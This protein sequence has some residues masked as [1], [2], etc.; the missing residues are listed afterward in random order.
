[1]TLPLPTAQVEQ[2]REAARSGNWVA[3]LEL[4]GQAVDASPTCPHTQLAKGRILRA[5]GGDNAASLLAFRKASDYA[6]ETALR[7][8]ALREYA[9]GLAT[10]G[11]NK[12]A[13]CALEEAITLVQ[14]DTGVADTLL[15]ELYFRASRNHQSSGNLERA[16]ACHKLSFP[17]YRDR[18]GDLAS[19]YAREIGLLEQLGDV[20]ALLRSYARLVELNPDRVLFSHPPQRQTP[21]NATRLRNL[22]LGINAH[23]NKHPQDTAARV[24]KAGLFYRLGRYRHAEHLIRKALTGANPHFY[25]FH[26]LGK[27]QLKLGKRKAAITALERAHS[28][29]GEYLDLGRDRALAHE[30]TDQLENANAIYRRMEARWPLEADTLARAAAVRERLGLLADAYATYRRVCVQSV[31]PERRLLLILASLAQ[32][33]GRH[34]DALGHI[35]ELLHALG[36]KDVEEMVWAQLQKAKLLA[37]AGDIEAATTEAE[38]VL[39]ESATADLPHGL[40]RVVRLQ[41]ASLFCE[42]LGKPERAIVIADELLALDNEDCDAL[43]VRG[44]ALLTEKQFEASVDAYGQAADKR[45]A[46]ALLDE[47]HRLFESAQFEQAITKWNEAFLKNPE[48]W[49][50]Y[51]C[52]A[53][54]YA[55]LGQAQQAA[56]YITAAAKH[57]RGALRL[58]RQDPDFA[59][60]AQADEFSSLL[61][62]DHAAST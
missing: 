19:Y 52:A 20:P 5:K 1:M 54:G 56:R 62:N 46:Q 41:T 40:R 9:L 24:F 30:L 49:E 29:G 36:R 39:A 4:I 59:A 18:R 13:A 15:P 32:R 12:E 22:L 50:V 14:E 11:R 3:A 26:L 61:E 51:Y 6:D 33:M 27:I 23:L 31:V 21:T 53:A 42:P 10:I 45:L 58:M 48:A 35:N 16:L 25:G 60:V 57:N 47:G 37:S 38:Q 2:A 28:L 17:Y 8:E 55:G 7:V 44:D 34:G 43:I